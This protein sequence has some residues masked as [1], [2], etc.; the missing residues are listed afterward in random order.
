MNKN[1]YDILYKTIK[2]IDTSLINC[3]KINFTDNSYVEIWG[4][5]NGPLGLPQIWLDGFEE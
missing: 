1:T 2:S 4:E 5:C 3:W